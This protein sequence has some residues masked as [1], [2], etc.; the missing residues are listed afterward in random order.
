MNEHAG[1]AHGLRAFEQEGIEEGLVVERARKSVTF[2]L[3]GFLMRGIEGIGAAGSSA[4][5]RHL[6]WNLQPAMRLSWPH[7]ISPPD[8]MRTR[9]EIRI[10]G[11]IP[12]RRHSR[13]L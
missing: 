12:A 11:M 10:S 2:P 6:G 3:A 8:T 4:Y 1:L 13:L 5:L 7:A 9:P